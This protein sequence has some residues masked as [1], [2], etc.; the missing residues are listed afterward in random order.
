M[1]FLNMFLVVDTEIEPQLNPDI[2]GGRSHGQR[3]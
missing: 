2:S 1:T 3:D